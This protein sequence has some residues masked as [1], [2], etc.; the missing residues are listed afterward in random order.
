MVVGMMMAIFW[1]VAL[2]SLVEVYL[3]LP[4]YLAQQPRRQ[5][6]H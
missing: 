3:L 2:R 5:P 4:D 1:A 6:H